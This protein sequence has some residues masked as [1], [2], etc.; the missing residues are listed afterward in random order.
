MMIAEYDSGLLE[1][2]VCTTMTEVAVLGITAR[3]SC[4]LGKHYATELLP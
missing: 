4:I 1:L 2:E 3:A